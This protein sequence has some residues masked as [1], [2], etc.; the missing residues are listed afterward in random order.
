[1]TYFE[2]H[3]IVENMILSFGIYRPF[4]ELANNP[5]ILNYASE[6]YEDIENLTVTDSEHQAVKKASKTPKPILEKLEVGTFGSYGIDDLDL[7][8]FLNLTILPFSR[9][10]QLILHRLNQRHTR[11]FKDVVEKFRA[12][13]D[14]S[15]LFEKISFSMMNQPNLDIFFTDLGFQKGQEINKFEEIREDGWKLKIYLS[16]MIEFY[17]KPPGVK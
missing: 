7:E 5:G 11:F 16:S 2:S 12:T 1:M 14:P 6:I 13:L 10:V 17:I 9:K 15:S 8:N 3:L 4:I